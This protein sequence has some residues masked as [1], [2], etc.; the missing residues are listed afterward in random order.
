MREPVEPTPRGA[1]TKARRLRIYLACNGRCVCGVKVP[2]PGTVIDHRIPLAQGGPDTDDN[3]RYLCA[4]CDGVKTP[5]DNSATARA[6]R[7]KAKHE[8]TWRETKRPIVS[9]GFDKTRS[10][11]FDG[12]VVAR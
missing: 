2:M 8:G 1:M 10:R 7:R 11:R 6:K 5:L 12:S 3:C 9:R 4:D